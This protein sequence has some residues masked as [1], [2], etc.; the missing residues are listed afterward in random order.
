MDSEKWNVTALENI[1]CC[2][3]HL[4]AMAITDVFND[5]KIL[6]QSL[7]KCSSK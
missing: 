5:R 4:V 1:I 6:P 3:K 7:E 2:I